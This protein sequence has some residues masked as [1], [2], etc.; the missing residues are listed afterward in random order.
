MFL[1]DG[2]G[3]SHITSIVF[4]DKQ[5]KLYIQSF[6]MVFKLCKDIKA[7]LLTLLNQNSSCKCQNLSL[8][9]KGLGKSCNC[10]SFF[11]PTV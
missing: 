4:E 11:I 9:L 5:L 2:L 8:L 6:K 1:K 10:F 3:F 7:E